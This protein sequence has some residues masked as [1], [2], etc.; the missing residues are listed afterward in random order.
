[1]DKSTFRN[2]INGEHDSLLS[3][4][5]LFRTLLPHQERDASIH[6][7]EEGRFIELALSQY[8]REKLPQG[9][10]V[11]SGFVIDVAGG[12]S[13]KQIDII[14]Y[15]AANF[16]PVMRYGDAVVVP[17][18]SVVGVLSVKRTLYKSQLANEL[19]ALTEIGSYAGGRGFPKP[20]LGIIAFGHEKKKFEKVVLETFD[21]IKNHYS[22]NVDK[23]G[24]LH[25]YSW[26]ELIDSVIVF[27]KFIIK[28]DSVSVYKNEPGASSYLL[29]GGTG[30]QRS[31]YIQHMLH[32]IHRAWYDARRGGRWSGNLLAIPGSKMKKLGV[33]KFCVHD[34]KYVKKD[35]VAKTPGRAEAISNLLNVIKRLAHQ[36]SVEEKTKKG[37]ASHKIGEASSK[38]GKAS[39][40]G[41]ER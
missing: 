30:A 26:N 14:L 23:K 41:G 36:R 22:P 34:R 2:F 7:G 40:S 6:S 16:A 4:I 29:T 38:G 35:F 10:G 21:G 28:G 39:K 33:V 18:Q 27:D 15:D 12:W 20:Y 17:V 19:L 5:D 32:G 37:K 13:S 8:L 24:R 25:Y 3:S 31:L 1:M 11:G 9:I